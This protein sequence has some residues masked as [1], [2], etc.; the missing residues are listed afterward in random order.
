LLAQSWI[1][2]NAPAVL[3][4]EGAV[5]GMAVLVLIAVNT[6]RSR[7]HRTRVAH[8]LRPDAP[9]LIALQDDFL[10]RVP[11]LD[12]RPV[13]SGPVATQCEPHDDPQGDVLAAADRR[14][15]GTRP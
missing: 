6:V 8:A 11:S 3:P 1:T 12:N 2:V 13:G 15:D 4:G 10:G 7:R 9:E 14:D 5:L